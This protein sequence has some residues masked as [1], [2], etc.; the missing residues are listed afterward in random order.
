MT[1]TDHSFTTTDWL[2][3]ILL[4]FLISGWF[5]PTIGIIAIICM[6]APVLYGLLKGGRFWCGTFCPRGSFL[7]KIIGPLSRKG[8]IPALIGSNL[9]RYGLLVFLFFNF[10]WGIYRAAGNTELIGRVFI[11]II[12]VTTLLGIAMGIKY[13][14]RTW[15]TV[16]PMGT[17]TTA[18]G[19]TRAYLRKRL[20]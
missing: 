13:Q 12:L 3:V 11:Q 20:H 6:I 18:A 17:L 15:C 19:K 8:R 4:G 9:F 10:A 1:E 14:P 16:C 5:F 2:W 7:A